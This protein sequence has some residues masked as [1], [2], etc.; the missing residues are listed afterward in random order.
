MSEQQTKEKLGKIKTLLNSLEQQ[1][2]ECKAILK[3]EPT[4]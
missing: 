1:I 2:R 4:T 3:G